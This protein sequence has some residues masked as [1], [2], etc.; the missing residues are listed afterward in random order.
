LGLN[1]RVAKIGNRLD[2]AAKRSSA[3]SDP[4]GEG[5]PGVGGGLGKLGSSELEVAL[6]TAAFFC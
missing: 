3:K 1:V 6:D 2:A 4:D 5:V